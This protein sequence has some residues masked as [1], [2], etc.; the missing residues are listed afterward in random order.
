MATDQSIELA[1]TQ[2]ATLAMEVRKQCLSGPI[3]PFGPY[4]HLAVR[5]YFAPIHHAPINLW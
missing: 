1:L 2:D 5:V 4:R 3:D